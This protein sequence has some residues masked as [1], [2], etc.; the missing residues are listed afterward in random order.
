MS[1]SHQKEEPSKKSSN[2]TSAPDRVSNIGD[3]YGWHWL[4]L[5]GTG[6]NDNQLRLK[7]LEER[8]NKEYFD[9]TLQS[10]QEKLWS[11]HIMMECLINCM[12]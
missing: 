10:A 2:G 11:T 7:A 1:S 5:L 6:K 3:A 8:D 9:E 4:I 12:K